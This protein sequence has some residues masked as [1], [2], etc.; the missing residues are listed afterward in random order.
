M[1]GY[2]GIEKMFFLFFK[3]SMNLVFLW[4]ENSNDIVILDG[5]FMNE[6]K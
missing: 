3:R 6:V 4:I 1:S 5:Y 2:R